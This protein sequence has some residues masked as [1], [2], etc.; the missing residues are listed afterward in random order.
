M[1]YN[2]SYDVLLPVFEDRIISCEADDVWP[3]RSYDLTP[4]GYYFCGG[5]KDKC[6]VDKPEII[7][8]LKDNIRE[9]IGEIQL[10]TIEIGP[11][12]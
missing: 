2:R 5:V 7:D 8:S 6:Y 12:A 4:L 3:L 1:P 10:R 9:T 11:I